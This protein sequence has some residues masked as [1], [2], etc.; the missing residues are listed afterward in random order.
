MPR[1]KSI[2]GRARIKTVDRSIYMQA[3][4]INRRLRSLE[5]AGEY[6]K[7]KA[8]KELIRFAQTNPYVSIKKSKRSKRHRVVIEKIKMSIANQRLIRKKFGSILK[9]K[10]FSPIGIRNARVKMEQ[11]LSETLSEQSD[12]EVT[13]ADVDRFIDIAEYAEQANEESILDKIG[14]SDFYTLVTEA[15]E[16][17]K[18]LPQ[19]INLLNDYV[20]INNDFMKKEA[21]ELYNKYVS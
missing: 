18:S 17:G 11:S 7:L 16:S 6:G 3:A 15:K 10:V 12:K 8:Q 19:W 1:K 5:K 4:K 21:E 20:M 14:P 2:S 13:K 9:S